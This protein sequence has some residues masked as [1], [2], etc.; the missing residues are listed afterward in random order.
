MDAQRFSDPAAAARFE[1]DLGQPATPMSASSDPTADDHAVPPAPFAAM[2]PPGAEW[3]AVA[4][5]RFEPSPIGAPAWPA[6]PSFDDGS[7][8]SVVSIN[9]QAAAGAAPA[10]QVDADEVA[11]VPSFMQEPVRNAALSRPGVRR[12]LLALALLL[13]LALAA[14]AA[15]LWRDRLA[16]QIPA[17]RPLLASACELVGCRIEPLRRIDQLSVDASGL[18]HIDGAPLHR[19]SLNLRNRAETAVACPSIELTLTDALGQLLARR[20]MPLSEFGVAAATIG[21]GAELPLQA[22]LSTGDRRISGYTVELFYP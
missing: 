10:L 7:P 15:L 19:L 17:L 2:P 21:A 8:A 1:F 14:Q 22:L 5:P 3:A 20:V 6:E 13:G 9:H 12:A 18:T 4:Q 16:A 11:A